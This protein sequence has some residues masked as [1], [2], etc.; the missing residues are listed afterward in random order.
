VSTDHD[1]TPSRLNRD[2]YADPC[3]TGS[4]GK[5]DFLPNPP[6]LFRARQVWIDSTLRRT[7]EHLPKE[8]RGNWPQPPRR[9]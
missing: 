6:A 3:W 7:D 1:D 2:V 4:G 9:C 8:L 5:A